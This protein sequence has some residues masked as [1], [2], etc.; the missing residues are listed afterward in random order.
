MSISLETD[1]ITAPSFWACYL[2]N[3]DATYM[4]DAE[5]NAADARFIGWDV[6]DVI[7]ASERFTWM[8]DVYGGDASGGEVCDYVVYRP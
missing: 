4:S 8:Y 5:C 7:E 1:V 3:G 6:V 2:I